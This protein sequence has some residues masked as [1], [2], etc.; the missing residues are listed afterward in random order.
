MNT[1]LGI[2]GHF[3]LYL[4]FL[5]QEWLCGGLQHFQGFSWDDYGEGLQLLE[6]ATIVIPGE[7]SPTHPPHFTPQKH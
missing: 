4:A 1:A 5:T 3:L 2:Q 6:G 7:F